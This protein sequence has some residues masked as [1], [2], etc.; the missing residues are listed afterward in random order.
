[1]KLRA[2]HKTAPS[3]QPKPSYSL[4]AN[5]WVADGTGAAAQVFFFSS[6]LLSLQ[7]LECP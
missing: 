3:P 4:G 6:F 1:M 2:S 7:F 5:G